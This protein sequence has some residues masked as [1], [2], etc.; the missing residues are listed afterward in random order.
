[1]RRLAGRGIG[2]QVHYMPLYR[3]PYYAARWNG[4]GLPGAEAYYAGTLSLPLYYGMQD[5][6]VDR[7]VSALAESIAAGAGA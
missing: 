1:M 5:G 7:V 6:D 3:Q 2:S 4:Q